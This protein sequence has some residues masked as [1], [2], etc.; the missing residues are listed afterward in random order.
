MARVA[1]ACDN[2]IPMDL[3]VLVLTGGIYYGTPRG[4]S[5]EGAET[6]AVNTM[7]YTRGEI[8]R[9]ARMAFHPALAAAESDE[10]G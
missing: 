7:V 10:R 8:E 4:I 2:K 5:G 9:V 3:N 6:R 1:L